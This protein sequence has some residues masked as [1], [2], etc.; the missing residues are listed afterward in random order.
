[1][2]VARLKKQYH[3]TD[4]QAESILVKAEK[5][6]KKFVSTLFG[7]DLCDPSRY[8]IMLNTADL[9]VDECASAS[10]RRWANVS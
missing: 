7:V 4:E 8:H 9:S 1:V 6:Q 10:S 3:V 5:K 2:R